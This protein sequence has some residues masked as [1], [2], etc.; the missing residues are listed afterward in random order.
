MKK[1][2]ALA[3]LAALSAG[4]SAANLFSDGNFAD[5]STGTGWAIDSGLTDGWTVSL[6]PKITSSAPVGLEVRKSGVVGTT[7]DGSNFIE[8]DGN[9]NDEI[10]TSLNTKAGEQYE[11]TFLYADRAGM[12]AAEAKTTG[13][14]AYSLNGQTSKYAGLSFGQDWNTMTI[15]FT[16]ST[17]KT[18]FSIWALG[19]SDSY[20]TSFADFNAVAVPEPG[21]LGLLAAGLAVIGLTARRRNRQ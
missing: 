21:S 7:P 15:D 4:A 8:L 17:A 9:Q 12:S 20:G 5:L 18:T 19:A 10:T 6:A 1:I 14:F 16:A 13:G 3:A 2:I 11:I